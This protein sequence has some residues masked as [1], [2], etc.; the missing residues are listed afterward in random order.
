MNLT[1]SHQGFH[2]EHEQGRAYQLVNGTVNYLGISYTVLNGYRITNFPFPHLREFIRWE[3]NKIIN[4][5]IK[6]ER[7]YIDPRGAV[8]EAAIP[9]A[10][11]ALPNAETIEQHENIC[12]FWSRL[13]GSNW[14][15]LH[16][17]EK[18]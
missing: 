2:H 5:S 12:L 16:S 4:H 13:P 9:P 7:V 8:D 15:I 10:H 6:F 3:D 17:G 14:K 18:Y 11:K 1:L